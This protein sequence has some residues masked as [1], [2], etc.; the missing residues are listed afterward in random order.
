[1]RLTG[2]RG[3]P[4]AWESTQI[5]STDSAEGMGSP[6]WEA[7][8]KSRLSLRERSVT[9][10]FTRQSSHRTRMKTDRP[11]SRDLATTDEASGTPLSRKATFRTMTFLRARRNP[12]LFLEEG[13]SSDNRS[14]SRMF[15]SFGDLNEFHT[16]R[17]GFSGPRR[18]G[19]VLHH[20]PPIFPG[21]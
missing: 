20:S 14:S 8:L 18:R 6:H 13:R 4:F 15:R 11:N 2:N 19:G 7:N 21:F 1:M 9:T 5:G 17:F 10:E 3:H 16:G 12:F